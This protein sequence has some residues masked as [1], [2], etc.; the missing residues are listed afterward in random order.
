MAVAVRWSNVSY[1]T[2]GMKNLGNQ[3]NSRFPTRSGTSDG[4][5][6]DAAHAAGTSD[7]D[8]D[9]SSY[10]NAAWDSD[11]DNKS[12]VRAI[13][14]DK[15]LNDSRGINMQELI[16]H[17]RKLPGLKNVIRYMIYN[18]KMYHARDNFAPTTY[19]GSN[20]HTQHAH[21]TGAWTQASDENNSF[22]YKFEELGVRVATQFNAEDRD[23]LKAEATEGSIGYVGGCLPVWPGK[24]ATSN[25][26]NAFTYMFN[27]VVTNQA[28]LE[29]IAAKVDLDPAELEAIR[30]LV[31]TPQENAQAVIQALGEAGVSD[32]ADILREGLSVEER[33]ELAALLLA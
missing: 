10:D 31:P 1:L 2:P 9:D 19:T 4:A 26:L 27:M 11:S 12:E 6:G 24:T 28:I 16:D 15:D 32:L 7:H 14:V 5:V 30:A 23:I 20:K 33:E 13:D 17:M 8:R 21:F 18:G 3:I 29:A 22:D 25:F